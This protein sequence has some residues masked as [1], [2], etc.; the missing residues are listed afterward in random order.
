MAQ[1]TVKEIAD[2]AGVSPATVSRV[3]NGTGSVAAEK[4]ERVLAVLE[5]WNVERP[6]RQAAGRK[7]RNIGALLPT[8]PES[9]SNAVLRKLAALAGQMR[10]N[11]NLILL[12]P[13]ILPMELE[14]R[15]L[16]GELAGLLLIGHTAESPELLQTLRGIPH[17]WL[18]SHRSGAENPTVLMGNEFAGRIAAR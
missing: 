5:E 11:W 6:P 15:H 17:V 10:P 8:R 18:N 13:G 16:H 2:R 12:P 9:D 4:R 14:T 7:T 3:V 1:H